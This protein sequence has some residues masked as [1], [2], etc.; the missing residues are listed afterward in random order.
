MTR[1][2]TQ[3]A[4]LRAVLYARVST[5]DGDQDPAAQ[6]RA[7]RDWCKA[8]GWSVVAEFADRV[9]GD[10]ARRHGDPNGLRNALQLL[11][12]RRADVLAVFAADRLVRS[13]MGLLQLVARV[14]SLGGH[15]ASYEDGADLDTT[16]DMGE[17]LVFLRGWW[18]RMQLRLLRRMTIAGM[19]EA[20]ARGVHVGRPRL[21]VDGAAVVKLRKRRVPWPSVAA[22]LGCSEATARRAARSVSPSV[23]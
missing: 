20:R 11:A 8:R 6:L 7:L 9:T 12:Q 4:A 23:P 15:V 13:P 19:N 10:P 21:A 2:P 1:K 17:L 22:K 16:T 14:Q 3:R 18:S 5:D